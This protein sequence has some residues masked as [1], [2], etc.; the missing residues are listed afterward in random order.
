MRG[1]GIMAL[2]ASRREV[3]FGGPS[4]WQFFFS[5]K[6]EHRRVA[7]AQITL[8]FSFNLKLGENPLAWASIQGQEWEDNLD[9]PRHTN[10]I[11]PSIKLSHPQMPNN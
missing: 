11:P 5:L 1:V 4:V 2:S 6:K 8:I 9:P 10:Q 7:T 3:R